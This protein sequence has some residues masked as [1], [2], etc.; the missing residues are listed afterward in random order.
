[1]LRTLI[2]FDFILCILG[3]SVLL[4]SF[5]MWLLS[6]LVPIIEQTVFSPLCILSP[7]LPTGNLVYF[8]ALYCIPYSM[9]LFVCVCVCVCMCLCLCVYACASIVLFYL[10]QFCKMADIREPNTSYSSFFSRLLWLFRVFWLTLFTFQ[11]YLFTFYKKSMDIL[12]GITLKSVD[13]FEQYEHFNNTNYFY[14]HRTFFHFFLTL[15]SISFI[16][17]LQFSEHRSLISL[18]KFIP[19]YF[20]SF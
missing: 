11:N 5:Y 15:S 3:R 18:I 14:K 4:L 8:G 10:P 1:M 16:S 6:F 7:L 13:F 12:I 17:V 9:W 2:Q 19:S 20:F